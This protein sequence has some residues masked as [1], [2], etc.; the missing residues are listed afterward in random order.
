M[1]PI[2]RDEMHGIPYDADLKRWQC[3]RVGVENF[4]TPVPELLTVIEYLAWRC[5]R[6]ESRMRNEH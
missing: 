6:A 4:L 5:E 1:N 3:A 2:E